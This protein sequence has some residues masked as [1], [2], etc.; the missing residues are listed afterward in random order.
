MTI[1]VS[2]ATLIVEALS[3]P[4]AL[5][6]CRLNDLLIDERLSSERG[7]PFFPAR[8]SGLFPCL[9]FRPGLSLFLII[10]RPVSINFQ[11]VGPPA[12]RTTPS[13]QPP[14]LLFWIFHRDK[15]VEKK[16]KKKKGGGG[17]A[18]VTS[19]RFTRGCKSRGERRGGR[20][21]VKGS[22]CEDGGVN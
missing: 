15:C 20:A 22:V 11:S 13:D 12:G 5:H 14:V 4:L 1:S 16:E 10:P 6:F 19:R 17:Q 8:V 2:S 9:R 3:L 7:L 21:H 18:C